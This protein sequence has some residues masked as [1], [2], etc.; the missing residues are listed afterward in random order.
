[1]RNFILF[2][3]L[4]SVLFVITA[5]S[6]DS[7]SQKDSD[8][9]NNLKRYNMEGF[10]TEVNE[11]TFL[12]ESRD[13]IH[14]G[15]VRVSMKNKNGEIQKVGKGD[16]VKVNYDGSLA[17]SSPAQITGM[18]SVEILQK[19]VQQY[20]KQ[21]NEIEAKEPV[22]TKEDYLEMPILTVV[23]NGK[24]RELNKEQSAFI[25]N[26][27][28]EFDWDTEY[29]DTM[30]GSYQILENDNVIA[31]FD[32]EKLLILDSERRIALTLDESISEMV[33]EVLDNIK[34]SEEE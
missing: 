28:E 32:P 22:K 16:V 10:V 25:H 19:S 27:L 31:E 23:V 3:M 8:K 17:K 4:V 7:D 1:M 26:V 18:T 6:S 14:I 15:D 9:L 30:K 11:E 2:V 20:D 12:M 29:K 5:C 34:K 21:G 13:K 24:S 33:Q